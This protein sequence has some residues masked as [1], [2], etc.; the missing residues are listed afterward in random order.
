MAKIEKIAGPV[1]VCTGMRGSKMYDLVHVGD[2]KIMGEIIQL[3]ND[4]ATVQVYEDTTSL[5]PGEPVE[6]TK[7]PLSIELGPGLINSILDGIGR[8]LVKMA[9]KSGNYIER[10]LNIPTLDKTVKYKFTPKKKKGDFVEPGK[11]IGT[12]KESEV[13]ENRLLVPEGIS[14]KVLEIAKGDLTV[15][16]V[17]ATVKT[18]SGTKKI[19]VSHKWPVRKG[20]PKSERLAPNEPLLTGQRVFDTFFPVAKGG[21]AAIPGPFGAGKT[22]SQHQITKWSDADVIVYV[23]CGERGNEMTDVLTELPQLIDPKTGKSLMQR[24]VLIANTSNMPVAAREASI[25]TGIT[26]AEYY[27]D[28]GYSVALMADST[29]RWAEA[30]REISSRLEEMPGEEG[31]PAYLASRLAQF[32][33]RAG[34]V[35]TLEGKESSVTVIGAV[36][37]QGGDFSEPVTQ[38]TLR[39]VKV[40]WALESALA[41]KRHFP[42]INW[43]DSYSLYID[44]LVDYYK[45]NVS[46]RFVDMRRK[47]LAI[48]KEEERLLEIVRLVGPDA[49]P[50]SDKLNLLTAKAIREDFLQQDAFHEVDSYCPMPKQNMMLEIILY[51]HERVKDALEHGFRLSKLSK[52]GVSERIAKLKYTRD[53]AQECK[54]IKSLI[55]EGVKQQT[56]LKPAIKSNEKEDGSDQKGDKR[57][58]DSFEDKESKDDSSM[59]EK[60]LSNDDN[61]ESEGNQTGVKGV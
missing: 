42:S 33:E 44:D 32:Y 57:R 35:K 54:R 11:C 9:A 50:E 61:Q 30:M 6:T 25:Y 15:D 51:L 37:P 52:M 27:R 53:I 55:D 13:I 24:T 31:Y 43:T 18:D 12:L 3:K 60:E 22:V 39:F 40:F 28:M 48:L 8:P 17:A 59:P 16:S 47:A 34:K 26:I 19:Y 58:L 29:S 21:T 20:R 10:G 1:V 36:S 45:D 41:Y 49:L 38:S 4:T 56:E 14:G 7:A 5:K 23:G 2:Q 46:I